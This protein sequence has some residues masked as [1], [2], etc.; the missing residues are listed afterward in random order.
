MFCKIVCLNDPDVCFH[1]QNHAEKAEGTCLAKLPQIARLKMFGNKS[2][3]VPMNV[4][5]VEF[6]TLNEFLS[7]TS[8]AS[9]GVIIALQS[10]AREK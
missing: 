4:L 5:G 8:P 1:S 3:L 9:K 7:T 10:G 2:S 6:K